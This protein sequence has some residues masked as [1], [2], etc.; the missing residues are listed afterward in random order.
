MTDL[1][2][3]GFGAN[4]VARRILAICDPDSAPLKRMVRRAK[5]E[6]SVIDVTYGRRVKTLIVLDT[7][8]IV[9]VALQPETIAGRLQR[10]ASPRGPGQENQ[11]APSEGLETKE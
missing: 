2:H 4:V 10:E 11:R 1:L 7:G 5:E 3:V 6:G 8:H 9:L